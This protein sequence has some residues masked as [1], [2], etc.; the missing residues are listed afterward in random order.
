MLSNQLHYDW[1]LRAL[2]TVVN[3]CGNSLCKYRSTLNNTSTD[4]SI[5]FET[6]LA[7]QALRINTISKLT[8]RDRCRFDNLVRDVFLST[9]FVTTGMETLS[10]YLEESATEL[11]M[12]IN[13]QQ[14]I[15][16]LAKIYNLKFDIFMVSK[17]ID[18]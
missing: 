2:K 8:Y 13:P 17:C 15:I 14:V 11:K 4:E 7:V 1:G 9:P 16:F 12:L 10:N 18:F 6:E 5:K 3:S